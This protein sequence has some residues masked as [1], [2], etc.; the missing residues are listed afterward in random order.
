MAKNRAKPHDLR[1]DIYKPRT[2]VTDTNETFVGA[3][4]PAVDPERG[5]LPLATPQSRVPA[6]QTT[7][8]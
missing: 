6:G 3:A 8:G 1:D 7:R 5:E 4:P 2:S